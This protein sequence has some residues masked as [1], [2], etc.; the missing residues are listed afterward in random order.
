MSSDLFVYWHRR[1]ARGELRKVLEDYLGSA[2]EI[3]WSA[4]RL[5]ASFSSPSSYPLRRVSRHRS[6]VH[7]REERWFEVFEHDNAVDVI[8]R[9]QDDFVQA[10]AAGFAQV[11]VHWLGGRLER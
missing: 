4:G 10:V 2:A 9:E 7:R 6:L 1:P 11:C 5:F 3:T 8:T